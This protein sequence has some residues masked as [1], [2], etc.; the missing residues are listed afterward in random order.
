MTSAAILPWIL[1]F[2]LLGAA[3]ELGRLPGCAVQLSDGAVSR[4]HLQLVREAAQGAT[5][6]VLV[7]VAGRWRL[8]DLPSAFAMTLDGAR[9]VHVVDSVDGDP[10]VAGLVVLLA[11]GLADHLLDVG[12]GRLAVSEVGRRG[13]LRVLPTPEY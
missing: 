13:H 8:L 5:V 12:E 7:E 10:V 1:V 2:P 11:H 3:P 9:W 6:R 4:R